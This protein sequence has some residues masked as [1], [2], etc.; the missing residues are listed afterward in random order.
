MSY[1][2]FAQSIQQ[3]PFGGRPLIVQQPVIIQQPIIVQ[4]PAMQQRSAQD[5]YLLQNKSKFYD[6][7]GNLRLSSRTTEYG[8]NSSQESGSYRNIQ[9]GDLSWASA[10]SQPSWRSPLASALG[11]PAAKEPEVQRCG[12]VAIVA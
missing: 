12:L 7:N 10:P 6:E 4:Q 3:H 5:M 9:P 2:T 11:I 1:I 8:K